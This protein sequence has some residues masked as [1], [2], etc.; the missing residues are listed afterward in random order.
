M[1]LPAP[2]PPGR[3]A[4]LMGGEWPDRVEPIQLYCST[5]DTSSARL[6]AR[7]SSRLIKF[8][9]WRRSGRWVRTPTSPLLRPLQSSGWDRETT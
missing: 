7:L 5:R 1:H 4:A 3:A 8:P 9:S 2:S 6:P